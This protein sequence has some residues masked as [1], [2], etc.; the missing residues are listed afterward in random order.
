MY[1]PCPRNHGV[2]YNLH[3]PE[4]TAG[5]EM[6]DDG[7]RKIPYF[8]RMVQQCG[9]CGLRLKSSLPVDVSYD[10]KQDTIQD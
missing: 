1:L 9:Q 7:V 2:M 4:L 8:L 3:L 6:I 5:T 10:N